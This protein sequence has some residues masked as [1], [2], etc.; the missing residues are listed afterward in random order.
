MSTTKTIEASH[1][2]EE[3]DSYISAKDSLLVIENEQLKLSRE[4]DKIQSDM[5]RQ[6]MTLET[7]KNVSLVAGRLVEIRERSVELDARQSELTKDMNAS[8]VD[9]YAQDLIQRGREIRR[10]SE[11]WSIKQQFQFMAL[12]APIWI[13]PVVYYMLQASQTDQY[14]DIFSPQTFVDIFMLTSIVATLLILS[15]AS[16]QYASAQRENRE[17]SSTISLRDIEFLNRLNPSLGKVLY[18]NRKF[19]SARSVLLR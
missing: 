8:G 14:F 12:I 3:L 19:V 2:D 1:T 9:I 5:D 18:K 17:L 11:D 7:A 15:F 6:P 4:W 10:F 16:G 13:T